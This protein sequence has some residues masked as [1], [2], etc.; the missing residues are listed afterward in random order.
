MTVAARTFTG[1]P[2]FCICLGKSD[3]YVRLAHE[4]LWTVHGFIRKGCVFCNLCI[5]FCSA[6]SIS[7]I[8]KPLKFPTYTEINCLPNR[9]ESIMWIQ[10]ITLLKMTSIKLSVSHFAFWFSCIWTQSELSRWDSNPMVAV[11]IS[12]IQNMEN[13]NKK[14]LNEWTN[15]RVLAGNWH[16]EQL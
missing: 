6:F 11:R 8:C 5:Q 15:R 2:M 9:T 16:I 10:S 1:I 4:P 14:Y 13:W 3:M 7:I 12:T